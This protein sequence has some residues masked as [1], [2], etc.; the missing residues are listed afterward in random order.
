MLTANAGS[1]LTFTWS[2]N[3]ASIPG[4]TSNTY[5]ATSSGSYTVQVSNATCSNTST[6]LLVNVN[7]GPVAEITT[8]DPTHFC[9]GASVLLQANSGTGLTYA[10]F[11]DGAMIPGAVGQSWEAS[12]AGS[13]TVIVSGNGCSDTSDPLLV[14]TYQTTAPSLFIDGSTMLCSGDST[15]I[16]TNSVAD[17][18]LWTLDGGSIGNSSP[19][20]SIDDG[21]QYALQVMADGCLSS[22]AVLDVLLMERPSADIMAPS[23]T[24]I[25][26][27]DSVTLEADAGEDVSYQWTLNG[28][29]ISGAE[30]PLYHATVSGAYALI[31][32]TAFCESVSDVIE[33][34]VLPQLDLMVN[35]AI[36]FCEGDSVTISASEIDGYQYLWSKDGEALEGN[37]QASIT[38]GASGSY[39]VEIMGDGCVATSGSIDVGVFSIP[40]ATVLAS[41][42]AT[43]C[44]G[45][46]VVLSAVSDTTWTYQ[47]S[48]DGAEIEA[49]IADT[50]V[51]TQGGAY[52]VM[53]TNGGCT[54]GS[55]EMMVTTLPDVSLQFSGPLSFCEGDSVVITAMGDSTYTFTWSKDN[56]TL[57]LAGPT[58]VAYESGVY[59]VMIDDGSC[60]ASSEAIMIVADPVPLFDVSILGDTTFCAGDSVMLVMQA[61][62]ASWEWTLDDQSISVADTL[63]VQQSGI[64]VANIINGGCIVQSQP[65][66]ITSLPDV[67]IALDGQVK[68]CDG[69]QVVFTAP[70]QEGYEYQWMLDGGPIEGATEH[71]YTADSPGGY[72]VHVEGA[73]CMATSEPIF[74][75]VFTPPTIACTYDAGTSSVSVEVIEGEGP[76]SFVWN[77]DQELD[78]PEM[79]VDNSGVYGVQVTDMNG[80]SSH[81][82]TTITLSVEDDCIGL[83][84][85][86]QSYWPGSALLM[87]QFNEAFPNGLY[88]GCGFRLMRLTNAD[89]VAQFLPSQG[90]SVRLPFGLMVDPG[91]TYNN[92]LAGELVALKLAVRFDEM[93]EDFSEAGIQLKNAVVAGGLFQ[94]MTVEDLI[95]EADKKIGGCF[96]WYSRL[97]LRNALAAINVGYSGGTVASG[98]LECPGTSPAPIS[99]EAPMVIELEDAP[100][101]TGHAITTTALPNPFRDRT[102]ILVDGVPEKE[103]I[104]VEILTADGILL[105]RLFDGEAE[106]QELRFDWNASGRATGVYI[107]R[108]ISMH[109]VETGR[110]ILQ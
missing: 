22:P 74:L 101:V 109:G 61:N 41:G 51:A 98:Y 59:G 26:V 86:Q 27:G 60:Q 94:G 40:D 53:V 43:F 69:E 80:C 14:T 89:A 55:E 32:G 21:G 5:T 4:A 12:E 20:I 16:S 10:W 81:C 92:S 107:Y 73:G 30:G 29:D 99:T 110:L 31:V 102:T 56:D 6:P 28:Q 71:S 72:S 58:L 70:L 83:R 103:R 68:F 65:F 78:G 18:Y 93:D 1:G 96:S 100:E 64:L 67:T 38:V 75:E 108:V 84:S 39:A 52:V 66:T 46:S 106:E 19:A 25:C 85:E 11:V 24:T 13:Y 87:D 88:I 7:A 37:D 77:E 76:F 54:V 90:P 49:A 44:F 48:V 35:G 15:I 57:D 34:T 105:E 23:V 97:Q 91:D 3:G 17:A 63:V 45:D 95:W 33:I 79:Q 2:K 50:L 36:A 9:M 42:P 104:T 47:W 82:E 62:G 8:E